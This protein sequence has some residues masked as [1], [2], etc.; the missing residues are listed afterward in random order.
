MNKERPVNCGCGGKAIIYINGACQAKIYCEKCG[1]ES[2]IFATKY[3]AIKAWNKAMGV[4]DIN[5]S[6]KTTVIIEPFTTD[7]D[8]VGYC[9]CGYLVNAEWKYCPS[10]GTRLE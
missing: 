3:E 6:D 10:C 7:M 9:K 1:I 2:N 5:V 4:K 8:H